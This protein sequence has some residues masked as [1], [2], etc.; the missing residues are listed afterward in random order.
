MKLRRLAFL[1]ENS[2][3]I[4]QIKEICLQA[5]ENGLKVLVFSF[6]KTDVLYQLKDILDHTAKEILSGYISPSRR[7]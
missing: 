7:Q 6:F 3:K 4:N 1:G 5:R 2:G